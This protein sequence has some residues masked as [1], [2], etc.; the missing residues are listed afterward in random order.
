M[1]HWDTEQIPTIAWQYWGIIEFMGQNRGMYGMDSKRAEAHKE[2]C[3]HYGL[4]KEE[5]QK[6][7]D[8]LNRIPHVP[9]MHSELIKL[10]KGKPLAFIKHRKKVIK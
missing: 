6:V 5:S 2:L 9:A 8:F 4:T 7:T 10:K 3:K 1:G